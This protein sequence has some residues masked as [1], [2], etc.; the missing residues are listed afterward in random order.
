MNKIAFVLG[1][2]L[3]YWNSVIMALAILAGIVFFWAVFVRRSDN[4]AGAALLC[5]LAVVAS[6]LCARLIHWYFLADSYDGFLSAMTD[7]T[8]SGYALSGA[9]FGCL[10]TAALLRVLRIVKDLPLTLD[11][12]VIGGSA[13]IAV[14]RLG[15]FFTAENRGQ[16]LEGIQSLPLVYPVVNTT[17]GAAEYRFATFVFQSVIAAV[18]FAILLT[19]FLKNSEKRFYRDGDITLVF[20]LM[21]SASQVVLD[22]TRYDALRLRSNGFISVVQVLCAV[23]LVL[24]IVVFSVRLCKNKGWKPGYLLIWV[25]VAASVGLAAYMEYHVQRHGDQALFAYSVMSASLAVTV[26]SGMLLWRMSHTADKAFAT[27]A[28]AV[29][30]K[31]TQEKT[32]EEKPRRKPVVKSAYKG[33]YSR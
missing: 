18:L 4:I 28:P 14:G 8:G 21:Y 24:S 15:A 31:Q 11:S 10:L 5:P 27:A 19:M 32:T 23:A 26:L 9:F 17:S 7:F 25:L 2:L 33:K 16:I 3:I 29:P 13:A 6:L 12:M 20:L 22:S 1:D 30:V